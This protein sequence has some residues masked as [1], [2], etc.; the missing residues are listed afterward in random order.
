M[1]K[2]AKTIKAKLDVIN[3]VAR[4]FACIDNVPVVCPMSEFMKYFERKA[5]IKEI[6]IAGE[7]YPDLV[8]K[9]MSKDQFNSI[10]E[11]LVHYIL[12]QG[13]TQQEWNNAVQEYHGN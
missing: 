5:E 12:K 9:R 4:N 10:K 3:H 8:W 1:K 7:E 2:K 13:I 6:Y 11:M